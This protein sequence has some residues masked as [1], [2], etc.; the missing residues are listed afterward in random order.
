VVAVL[1]TLAAP[2][3]RG[4]DGWPPDG[5]VAG[6]LGVLLAALLA[7]ASV[8]DWLD[9]RSGAVAVAV[10]VGAAT[11]VLV[12]LG[13]DAPLRLATAIAGGLVVYVLVFAALV[14]VLLPVVRRPRAGTSTA[15]GGGAAR[16][17][18]EAA[19]APAPARP[20]TTAP[21]A[22]YDRAESRSRSTSR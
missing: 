19:Q 12:V 5:W 6:V 8:V 15:P 1:L 14:T 18:A 7:A 13:G 4:L 20:S 3:L 10:T 21:S 22:G 16:P 17:A 9:R 11:A 2:G